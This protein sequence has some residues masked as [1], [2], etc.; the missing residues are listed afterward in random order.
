MPIRI[1]GW[2]PEL[3]IQLPH[4]DVTEVRSAIRIPVEGAAVLEIPSQAKR[5]FAVIRVTT[6]LAELKE[7][8]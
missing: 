4:L 7:K 6:A 5:L 8:K 1:A 2:D 3:K